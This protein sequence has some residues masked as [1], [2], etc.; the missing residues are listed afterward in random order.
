MKKLT[1]CL[2]VLLTV[3]SASQLLAITDEEIFR[4]FSINLSTP[5]A[6]ARAMGGAFIGRADDAT[7]AETNPAG[8]TI[9]VRPEVSFEYRFRNPRQLSTNVVQIPTAPGYD[10]SPDCIVNPDPGDNN[11]C[12]DP[13]AAEFHAHDATAS[14]N[15]LGFFSVVYPFHNIS[16]AF[17]R[18]ELINTDATVAGS[19]SASPFHFVEANSF[20]GNVNIADTNYGFSLAGR[21]GDKFS[22]GATVKIS[23]FGF[24]SDIRAKQK[25][26]STY[27]DHFTTSIDNHS[28]KVGFNAGFLVRPH[29]KISIGGVYRYEPKFDLTAVVNNKDFK[30]NSL[31]ISHQ[32]ANQVHFDIPDSI[33]FGISITPTKNW[34]INADVLR[35]LYSQM[36]TVDTGYSLFTH[37]LP[38]CKLDPVTK[39]CLPGAPLDANHISFKVDDGT[40]EH[41]GAE[42][43]IPTANHVWALRGGYYHETR[44]R[45]FLAE[46]ANPDVQAFLQPIFGSNP[47]NDISHWTVGAGIT[48]GQFQVDFAVDLSQADHVDLNNGLKQEVNDGG[49]DFILSSV[50]RF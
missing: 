40:D 30:Q 22:V 3:C 16:F 10:V 18:H 39:T 12:N 24:V 31:I 17:S 29:P 6:R 49:F 25:D 23:D 42:Y 20:Q 36:E 46:A 33:G 5:G 45:F 19:L 11:N 48:H 13:V 9:L 1:Q 38:V 37:L 14:V 32:G 43:L 41:F 15:E 2:V 27:G 7:A 35:I 50:F 28:T 21:L 34:T 4:A 44:N 47:G 26:Q 8:L